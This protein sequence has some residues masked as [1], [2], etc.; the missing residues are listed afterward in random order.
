MASSLIEEV[1][2]VSGNQMRMNRL[3]EDAAQTF[4][5][6][7]PVQLNAT[8]GGIQAWN[9]TTPITTNGIVGIAKDFGA[10]LTTA[11]V[12]LGQTTGAGALPPLGG[13]VK[14]GTVPNMPGAVN[15]LRP[16]FNDG[17]CGVVL[18]ITDTVFFGQIGPTQ[19]APTVADIGVSM[20][21]TKDTDNHWFVD[22]TKT[23]TAAVLQVTGL[24]N[25]DTLRGVFFT[26]LPGVAKV[27]S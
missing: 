22:R 6:G 11:G 5:A 17:R 12:S 8:T 14:I 2:T 20:G 10:N 3:I 7:T 25:W 9:G 16:Y 13:G 15:L 23:G 24:P 26:F 27:L 19:A 4:L 1:G 21:L 18:A